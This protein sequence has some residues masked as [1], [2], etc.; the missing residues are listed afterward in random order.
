MTR[1]LLNTRL[2]RS[3]RGGALIA[4]FP[5][6]VSSAR[7]ESTTRKDARARKKDRQEAEKQALL[8][9]RRAEIRRERA[10]VEAAV[11]EEPPDDEDTTGKKKSKK[12][13]RKEELARL[14]ALKANELR[15]K[16]EKVS[17]EGGLG[18]VNDEGESC[19]FC[20]WFPTV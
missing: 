19:E 13:Q 7:R 16:L 10:L 2:R 3:Y 1:L 8:D 6:N 14:K 17:S 9:A 15:R 5:R 11:A 12:Q 18:G 4:S 20:G